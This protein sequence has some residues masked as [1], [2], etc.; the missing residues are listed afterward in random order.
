MEKVRAV[1]VVDIVIAFFYVF[2]YL[3]TR[4]NACSVEIADSKTL[5]SKSLRAASWCAGSFLSIIGSLGVCAV[6]DTVF[7]SRDGIA[8][9][10]MFACAFLIAS[11][12]F[13]IRTLYFFCR[14]RCS[15]QEPR[16]PAP[17]KVKTDSVLRK[18]IEALSRFVERHES[19]V[20]KVIVF[21]VSC[22][23]FGYWMHPGSEDLSAGIGVW[24]MFL[25]VLLVCVCA[26]KFRLSSFPFMKT[27]WLTQRPLA[28]CIVL[29]LELSVVALVFTLITVF[30][31]LF[32]TI[33]L[34]SV[35]ALVGFLTKALA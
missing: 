24:C 32:T 19:A 25:P 33:L 20:A 6:F 7:S 11:V 22:G 26:T 10:M 12:C 13:G 17:D 35:A 4:M 31:L 16:N 2:F 14:Y 5:R 30:S 9:A 8:V 18:K 28:R 27:Q 23:M 29:F 34:V 3:E 15:L 21:A 1:P